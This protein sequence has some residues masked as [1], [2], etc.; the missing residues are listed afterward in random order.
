VLWPQGIYMVA[1]G[2]PWV[3]LGVTAFPML[4]YWVRDPGKVDR[5]M[6]WMIAHRLGVARVLM[7]YHRG[8]CQGIGNFGPSDVGGED[9][10]IRLAVELGAH[11]ASRGLRIDFQAFADM[12]T[13][14]CKPN[15]PLSQIDQF[16]FFNKAG[17]RL[18]GWNVT[19][20]AGN[21]WPKNG[22]DPLTMPEPM[23]T[24]SRGSGL[25]EQLPSLPPWDFS[26]FHPG[27][28]LEFARKFKAV[29]ELRI[30]DT[31]E[32]LAVPGP[33]WFTEPIGIGEASNG[34]TTADPWQMWQFAAGCKL[35]G[36]AALY[37]H[38][39]SAIQTLDTPPEGGK[40]EQ[41][42]DAMVDAF[43]RVPRDYALGS[44]ARGQSPTE[45]TNT[46][47]AIAHDD[48]I[49]ERTYEL[50]TGQTS[51][52]IVVNPTPANPFRLQD[53]ARIVQS[54]GYGHGYPDTVFAM[55]R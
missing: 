41:C 33:I 26:E 46:T 1:N 8:N 13:D 53:G 39:R 35:F 31:N 54:Y 28:G 12:Q 51:G 14:D 18:I 19:L 15:N 25:E 32:K 20:G 4:E 7:M 22:F 37:G 47:I 24:S 48:S 55:T 21:Q 40:A 23:G 30:G 43:T 34:S 11:A 45:P 5:F 29:R 6:D 10:L 44:Y 36:V 16:Q 2:Q 50:R 27:R 52:V 38:L 3:G 42:I 9:A 49:A 17:H